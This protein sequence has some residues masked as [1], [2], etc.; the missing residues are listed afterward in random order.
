VVLVHNVRKQRV[1]QLAEA[2]DREFWVKVF[3]VERAASKRRMKNVD[4]SFDDPQLSH[5]LLLELF[6]V[7]H[8]RLGVVTVRAEGRV[9]LGDLLF[10]IS[11]GFF[12]I[13]K[14]NHIFHNVFNFFL[15]FPAVTVVFVTYFIQKAVEYIYWCVNVQHIFVVMLGFNKEGVLITWFLGKRQNFS[16]ALA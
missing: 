6:T 3:I 12:F 15:S 10:G 9:K 7:Q 14:G 16:V 11:D 8:G 1:T 2:E 5:N 4:T 13:K